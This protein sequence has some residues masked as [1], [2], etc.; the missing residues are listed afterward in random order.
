[1]TSKICVVSCEFGETKYVLAVWKYPYV[2]YNWCSLVQ[3]VTPWAFQRETAVRKT[4][5]AVMASLSQTTEENTGYKEGELAVDAKG[6]QR[7]GL[8][9]PG[10]YVCGKCNTS[11]N[12]KEGELQCPKCKNVSNNTLT[13][14]YTEE[15]PKKDEMM[16]QDEFSAGD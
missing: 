14:I 7:A 11:F 10:K 8:K 6:A 1:M 12:Y 15:D 5:P 16:G 13:A 9:R 3:G 2:S 4:A